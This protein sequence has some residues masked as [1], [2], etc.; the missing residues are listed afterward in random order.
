MADLKQ[1]IPYI[2][3]WEG[4]LSRAK[5]DTAS[6]N[7]APW[8]YKGQTGWHTNKG[9]TYQT[10]FGS[11]S[12]LGYQPTAENFFLMPEDIWMKIY[13]I[14]YWNPMAL[15]LVKSQAVAS[16]MADYAW[17][18]GV[19]GAQKQLRKFLLQKYNITASTAEQVATAINKL[20]ANGDKDFFEALIE[21]RKAAFKSLNQP[22]NEKGWL[23]RMDQ[24]KAVGLKLVV[25]NKGTIGSV[26]F[27]GALGAAYYFKDDLS[28]YFKKA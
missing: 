8:P 10:F 24:L 7:P 26:L 14:G 21:Q 17:G 5:S 12:K 25:E 23:S 22:A 20:T 15:D 28:N 2:K 19:G 27:I 11:A 3:A 9:I 1:I 16:A 13:R 4:G 6:A 18:W